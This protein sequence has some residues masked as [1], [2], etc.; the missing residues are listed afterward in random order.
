[1]QKFNNS[2]YMYFDKK[3]MLLILF[4]ENIP[5][6]INIKIIKPDFANMRD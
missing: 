3:E 6:Q 4:T 1:M 5:L 2:I